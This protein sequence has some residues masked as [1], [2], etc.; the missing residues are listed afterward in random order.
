MNKLKYK[1]LG[2]FVISGW[3][4][5]PAAEAYL[6]VRPMGTEVCFTVYSTIP[7]QEQFDSLLGNVIVT[8]YITDDY[9]TIKTSSIK[10]R[11]L[12]FEDP[13]DGKRLY[14]WASIVILT[15]KYVKKLVDKKDGYETYV[16]DTVFPFIFNNSYGEVEP[17]KIGDWI[18]L[19]LNMNIIY[20]KVLSLEQWLHLYPQEK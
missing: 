8:D 1:D 13:T 6:F 20:D 16:I 19:R 9:S 18:E 3:Y 11:T 5:E 15:G 17:A 14:R 10:E 2:F 7:N 4:Y 12:R